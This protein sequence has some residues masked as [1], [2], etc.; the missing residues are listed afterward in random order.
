HGEPGQRLAPAAEAP[1]LAL[2]P[3]LVTAHAQPDADA[4]RPVQQDR[5]HGGDSADQEERIPA[6]ELGEHVDDEDEQPAEEADPDHGVARCPPA[7]AD[8]L[9]PAAAGEPVVAAEGK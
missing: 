8:L 3:G 2:A 5:A 7:L 1:G 9:E 6:E 4:I